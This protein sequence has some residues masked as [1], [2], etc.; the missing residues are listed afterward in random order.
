MLGDLTY[1]FY[2]VP[3]NF[4]LY[5]LVSELDD[6]KSIIDI[7]NGGLEGEIHIA[8]ITLWKDMRKHGFVHTKLR[9]KQIQKA[10]G[11]YR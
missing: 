5:G 11:L 8:L 4:E 9:K 7:W 3:S 2:F 10:I 1:F 6:K